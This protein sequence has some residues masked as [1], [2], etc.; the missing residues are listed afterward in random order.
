MHN[1]KLLRSDAGHKLG[2][3]KRGLSL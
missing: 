2:S 3:K 1:R